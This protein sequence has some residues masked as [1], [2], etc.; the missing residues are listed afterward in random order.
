VPISLGNLRFPVADEGIDFSTIQQYC[1]KIRNEDRTFTI[2]FANCQA[3]EQ[4]V[5]LSLGSVTYDIKGIKN[6][7]CEM[8]Y[9]GEVENPEWDRKLTTK[10]K[11]P[12]SL[13]KVKFTKTAY[14]IGFS[15]ISE[16]CAPQKKNA[17]L[18]FFGIGQ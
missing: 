10:C 3:G 4:T 14:G 17:F 2:D 16:Y 5:W 11:V 9:G 6:D 13:G 8:D 1:V 12:A 18:E 7:L 15:P